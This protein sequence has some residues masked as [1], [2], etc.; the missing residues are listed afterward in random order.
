LIHEGLGSIVHESM[1]CISDTRLKTS[2]WRDA[3][4]SDGDS[5][6]VTGL[7]KKMESMT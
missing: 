6:V 2:E 7:D 3:I 4:F 1:R 5:L